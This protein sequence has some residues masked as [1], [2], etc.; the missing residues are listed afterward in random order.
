VVRYAGEQIFEQANANVNKNVWGN[1]IYNVKAYGA[2]GDG[3]TD[4]ST[5]IQAAIS[6]A[7][8]AGGG[9]VFFPA[10]TY[11]ISTQLNLFSNVSF[12]GVGNASVIKAKDSFATTNLSPMIWADSQSD[13]S[14]RELTLMETALIKRGQQILLVLVDINA[15]GILSRTAI[16]KTLTV[17]LLNCPIA[18]IHP[19]KAILSKP[20]LINMQVSC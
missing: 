5:A 1:I 17:I 8:T 12:E 11:L 14:I 20:H 15:R 6:A 18:F 13:I 9:K 19:S 4:D 7:N 16:L 2:K 10:G 3:V